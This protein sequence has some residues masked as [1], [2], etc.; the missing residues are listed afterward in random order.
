MNETNGTKN[1]RKT[2]FL[3][4]VGFCFCG[5]PLQEKALLSFAATIYQL[6]NCFLGIWHGHTGQVRFLHCVE[7]NPLGIPT[8]PPNNRRSIRRDRRLS[9]TASAAG[10]MIVL[11]GGDGYEDFR[12]APNGT[13]NAASSDG[14]GRDDS[15]NHL[16]LWQC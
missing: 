5:I 7:Q 1:R 14:A 4:Y 12:I 11:S 13:V 16:L 8:P 6:N 15:T 9:L 10:K 2:W 3:T